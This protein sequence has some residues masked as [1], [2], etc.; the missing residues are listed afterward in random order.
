MSLV[1]SN[2][3]ANVGIGN[4]KG[5]ML[6]NRPFGGSTAGIGKSAA[7]EKTSFTCGVVSETPGINVSISNLERKYPKRKKKETALTKHR[8]WLADLQKTKDR[9]ESQYEDELKQTSDQKAK[10][11]QKEAQMRQIAKSAKQTESDSKPETNS[12]PKSE[13]KGVDV[14]AAKPKTKMPRPAWALTEDVAEAVEDEKMTEDEDELI[15]FA[16]GLDFDKY[17]DDL[18]VHT[19]MERVKARIAQLEHETTEEERRD[20]EAEERAVMRM[21]MEAKGDEKGLSDL[22]GE[23]E[24]SGSEEARMAAKD[25]LSDAADMKGIHSTKSV[26]AVYLTAKESKGD[27]ESKVINQPKVVTHEESDGARLQLKNNPSTLPYIH[28][29]PAV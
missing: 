13:S 10:F 3:G 24:I 29:N 27:P 5:V 23:K 28:R 4:Y 21:Q 9:L 8:K 19:M 15:A 11:A 14:A 26:A 25:I 20:I 7:P 12:P 22:A 1:D 16:K 17:I 2:K 18:E 6:C